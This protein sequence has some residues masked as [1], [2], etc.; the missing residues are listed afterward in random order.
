MVVVPTPPA[1]PMTARLSSPSEASGWG[2]VRSPPTRRTVATSW[3]F[4]IESATTAFTA[5]RWRWAIRPR[6]VGSAHGDDHQVREGVTDDVQPV[7]APLAVADR[8]DQHRHV[9]IGQQ[10][11]QVVD[12]RCV[13]HLHA[14]ERRVHLP[15]HHDGVL[16]VLAVEHHER[17]GRQGLPT[18]STSETTGPGSAAWAPGRER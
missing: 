16:G 18:S 6:L 11:A 7:P 1:R 17:R 8:R 2:R 12:G 10:A 13:V 14:L 15:R 3:S 4:G 9:V 5:S